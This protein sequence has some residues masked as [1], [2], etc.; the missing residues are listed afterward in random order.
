MRACGMKIRMGS[1]MTRGGPRRPVPLLILRGGQSAR[2][3]AVRPGSNMPAAHVSSAL[4][5]ADGSGLTAADRW[6]EGDRVPRGEGRRPPI[7]EADVPSVD[8]NA[9]VAVAKTPL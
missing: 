2:T 1:A 3:R 5:F 7:E 4:F 6:E 9:E 8:E